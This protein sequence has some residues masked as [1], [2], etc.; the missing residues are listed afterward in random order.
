MNKIMCLLASITLILSV[1]VANATVI[2]YNDSN[3]ENSSNDG[4]PKGG[5]SNKGGDSHEGNDSHKDDSHKDDEH[6]DD[7]HKDDKHKDDKHKDDEHKD[8]DDLVSCTSSK[9]CGLEFEDIKSEDHC[10]ESSP[11]LCQTNHVSNPSSVPEPSTYALFGVGAA[12]LIWFARRQVKLKNRK[13]IHSGSN[14]IRA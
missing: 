8:V 5:D 4:K 12:G 14:R 3:D 6:K 10:H 13:E 11:S 2:N 1:A 7:E 9:G